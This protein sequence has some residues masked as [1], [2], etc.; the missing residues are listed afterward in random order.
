M[1]RGQSD[2]SRARP[3]SL[4]GIKHHTRRVRMGGCTG[5]FRS[6]LSRKFGLGG[7]ANG[8]TTI[9]T[10]QHFQHSWPRLLAHSSSL[11]RLGFS[12]LHRTYG[13]PVQVLFLLYQLL[14]FSTSSHS[15]PRPR[16]LPVYTST[17]LFSTCSSLAVMATTAR[18]SLSPLLSK[19]PRVDPKLHADSGR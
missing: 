9:T 11:Y 6:C 1:S 15:W 12:Q 3:Y 19:V 17:S 8:T 18:S 10:E 7:M 4:T 16:I 2:Y 13:L 5:W 14:L